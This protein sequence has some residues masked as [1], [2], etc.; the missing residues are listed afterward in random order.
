MAFTFNRGNLVK[1]LQLPLVALGSAV[2]FAI[3]RRKERWLFGSGGGVGEGS[4]AL[5]RA[6]SADPSLVCLWITRTERDER[7]AERLGLPFVRMHS[8]RGL[9]ATYRAGVIVITHGFG[10]V[11]R[12][13][14]Q[15]AFVVQM[16]H[17]IP[18]KRLHLDA[19]NTLRLG[20]LSA[21]PGAVRLVRRLHQASAAR[22]DLF[23]VASPRVASRIR[24]AFDLP[25]EKIAVLGDAR[26][27]AVQP[28]HAARAQAVAVLQAAGVP[29]AETV[30]GQ[31]TAQA[32]SSD[33]VV[34]RRFLYAPTWRDG[35][36]DPAVPSDEEWSIIAEWLEEENAQLL[37]RSHPL[38]RGAYEEGPRR[39]KRIVLLGHDQVADLNPILPAI[40]V[41]ITDYSSV[42]F[43]FALLQRP[44]LFLAP[45]VRS[46]IAMRGLYDPYEEFSGKSVERWSALVEWAKNLH[47]TDILEERLRHSRVLVREHI[48]VHG[49]ASAR[50]IERIQAMQRGAEVPRTE[51]RSDV[52]LQQVWR[53][54]SSLRIR[55]VHSQAVSPDE[56]RLRGT[57]VSVP[58]TLLP[59]QDASADAAEHAWE[60]VVPLMISRW[61]SEPLSLPSGVY[62]LEFRAHDLGRLRVV[63]EHPLPE[64]ELTPEFRVTYRSG[65]GGIQLRIDPPL[66]IHER[67]AKA[68]RRLQRKH[69]ADAKPLDAVFFES[70]YGQSASDNPRGID[71][72][73]AE[74]R[75]DLTR[76]WSTVDASVP[77]PEGAVRIIEGTEQWWRIR[78]GARVLVVNDWLRKRTKRF[79]HQF[80]LQT[81]HG[82][83]LKRLALDREN[84]GLRT[85]IATILE[86]RRWSAMLAQN[87]HS[88]RSFRSS[89][90]FAGPIWELGYPRADTLLSV[91]TEEVR[92]KLGISVSKRVVLYAPTWRD[93]RVAVVDHIDARHLQRLL[94]PEW[95]VLVRG[96]SRTLRAGTDLSSPGVIDATS[97]PEMA[98]LLAV[99]DVLVTDYSSVMFDFAAKEKPFVF[100]VPDIG[101]YR[102]RLRGFTFDFTRNAPGPLTST[103]EDAASAIL[104]PETP[105]F[106][107][108]RAEWRIEFAPL[109]DGQAGKRIVAMLES[110]GALPPAKQRADAT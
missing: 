34:P 24:T 20:P 8:L 101:D 77:I 7:D 109:D 49:D 13:A 48:D 73:L 26:V 97:Y 74:L 89:Y 55:G 28:T 54:G 57:R 29:L 105:E 103:V 58:I 70:F 102:D 80:V 47:E 87:S 62:E 23:P 108:R 45:D 37:I 50:V 93:D 86:G 33:E 40:D 106:A 56:V 61:G 99:A 15:G 84:V 94:G 100:F 9:L 14:V 21:I 76:Y 66:A 35:Q 25:L 52:R 39:S 27:D 32:R 67:G 82:T 98:D 72:A 2:S 92:R 17:G 3:P 79:A 19:A 22:I 12:F 90:R 75:P 43:D 63:S 30:T 71:R 41:L 83:P 95:V 68:Q 91:D 104:N 44:I 5:M 53:E 59:R 6:A 42:A 96:H 18:L 65:E 16:W 10:D 107:S 11:N 81:W 46:Y 78:A 64:P 1:L 36:P 85:R 38:G 4:L 88:A 60:A 31:A 51:P 69:F 110:S